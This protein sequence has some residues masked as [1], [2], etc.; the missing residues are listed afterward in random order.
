MSKVSS[1]TFKTLFSHLLIFGVL[2]G[3]YFFFIDDIVKAAVEHKVKCE[4]EDWIP[5][6][7]SLGSQSALIALIKAKITHHYA[8][9]VIQSDGAIL[10]DSE[11]TQGHK[12]IQPSLI[13]LSQIEVP[14]CSDLGCYTISLRFNHKMVPLNIA[15]VRWVYVGSG[16][17]FA[18]LF[19]ILSTTML[20]LFS[21]PIQ[22]LF[23]VINAYHQGKVEELPSALAHGKDEAAVFSSTLGKLIA[24]VRDLEMSLSEEKQRCHM[25]LEALV[26]GIIAVDSH[27]NVTYANAAG[28][29][30]IGM[31][32]GRLMDANLMRIKPKHPRDGHS[33]MPGIIV[34][35]SASAHRAYRLC[36]NRQK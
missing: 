34:S 33:K 26:E 3:G 11:S 23:R 5:D 17:G 13:P 1:A 25:I 36:G 6:I 31:P 20:I 2:M 15:D 30:M 16:I 18:V 28:A 19:I 8:F 27:L 7:Q 14:F 29:K 12:N 21:W 22:R 4:V 32:K 35:S 24:Q 10:F 9:Q